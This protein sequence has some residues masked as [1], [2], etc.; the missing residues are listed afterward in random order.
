MST[1][2]RSHWE[3]RF[4]HLVES[5]SRADAAGLGDV[6]FEWTPEGYGRATLYRDD[7]AEIILILWPAG[8]ASVLHGHGRS[9]ALLR[10][11]SGAIAEDRFLPAADHL[12][13]Q[14]ATL[15]AGQ[16]GYL[17]A[18]AF[19]RVVAL[20]ESL[21]LHAYTPCL[22]EAA[23]LPPDADLARALAAWRRSEA[24]RAGAPL[25]DYLAEYEKR[26]TP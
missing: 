7:E 4:H 3:P 20:A 14:P 18:G 16:T 2:S 17:P 21:G 23:A 19:H 10:L 13:H 1:Q 6:S 15:L 26:S 8:S 25:P 5:L 9:V 12:I 24:A 22:E 11:I